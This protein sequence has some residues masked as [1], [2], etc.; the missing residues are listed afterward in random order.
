MIK[1]L[2]FRVLFPICCNLDRIFGRVAVFC[3]KPWAQPQ[4]VPQRYGAYHDLFAE[5]TKFN[6][7]P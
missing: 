1:I 4:L 5:V 3:F 2:T 7:A 6:L